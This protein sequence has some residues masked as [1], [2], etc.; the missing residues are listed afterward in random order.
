MYEYKARY[1]K[2]VDGDTLDLDVDLG[3]H[4]KTSLRFRILGI[5][6]PE[7]N[8]NDP[9]EKRK[10]LVATQYVQDLLAKNPPLTIRTEKSDSFGRWLA[11]VW[12]TNDDKKI[13]LGEELLAKGL[14][15]PYK[16]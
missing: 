11:E 10:A 12:I 13:N 1:I 8:S 7:K 3:F 6:T 16:K 4:T 14:A 5:N 9:E 2:V 15:V